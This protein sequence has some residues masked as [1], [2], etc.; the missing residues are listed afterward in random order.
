MIPPGPI[1]PLA[2]ALA[3]APAP[4]AG[5]ADPGLLGALGD[6]AIPIAA[7]V[8]ALLALAVVAWLVRLRVARSKGATG[9]DD[10]FSRQL[11]AVAVGLV[12][13]LLAILFIPEWLIPNSVKSHLLTVV[14]LVLTAVV[15]LSSTTLASNAMAGLMLRSLRNF[16]PG[17]FVKVDDHF[18]RVTE[19]GLFHTEIQTEDRDL[20]TLPNLLLVQRPVTVIHASGTVVS[21][22]VSLGYDVDHG[23]A[24]ALFLR[25]AA[26]AGLDDPFVQILHLHD[27]AVEYRVAGFLR[28][29][30]T[31]LSSRSRLRAA[32]LD[33]LHAER[34]EI[35]SPSFMIQRP[36][37]PPVPAIPEDRAERDARAA[38]APE[39]KVFDKAESA[40]RLA[41]LKAERDELA[42]RLA[43]LPAHAPDHARDA[44]ARRLERLDADLERAAAERD[45][46]ANA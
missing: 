17:D 24:E 7:V 22:T 46:G 1:P 16:R 5:E 27:H 19:R 3:A 11:V 39:R 8:A 10:Q 13:L 30:K 25:A 4:A 20:T 43:S 37:D 21:A 9:P 42:Q 40:E 38:P 26:D 32:I 36:Q 45:D 33:T 44:L 23:R 14:G 12:A 41:S 34:V 28:E 2:P 35:A 6:A 29:V 31:V 15:T 18:G